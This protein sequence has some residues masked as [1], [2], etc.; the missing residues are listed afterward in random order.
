MK[1]I[2]DVHFH[3]RVTTHD[4]DGVTRTCHTLRDI[5]NLA[6]EKHERYNDDEAKRFVDEVTDLAEQKLA[7]KAKAATAEAAAQ[8]KSAAKSV[9]PD[10]ANTGQQS[11]PGT[12]ATGKTVATGGKAVSSRGTTKPSSTP[13]KGTG[14][15]KKAG[16]KK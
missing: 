16:G 15:A 5:V 13:A 14:A 4:A 12:V 10:D 9:M 7:E 11:K 3:Q 1:S 2:L 8:N 6:K